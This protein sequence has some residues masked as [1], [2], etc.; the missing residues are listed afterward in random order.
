MIYSVECSFAEPSR[1]GEWNEF[2]SYRKLPALISV[3]GFHTSQRF[4]AISAGCP[5]YLAI[6][7][8]DGLDVL[9]GEEYHEKGGGNFA[10][11]QPDITDWHRNLYD[12]V[13]LAPDVTTGEI[14]LLTSAGPDVLTRLGLTPQAMHAVAMERNPEHRWLASAPAADIPFLSQLPDAVHVYLPMTPRL[15]SESAPAST[16][17]A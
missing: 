12:G 7:T 4:K 5:V 11:W 1:E 16:T 3:S 6:H 8:I 9:D 10:R 15:T 2:Y 14:L 13:D 17:E